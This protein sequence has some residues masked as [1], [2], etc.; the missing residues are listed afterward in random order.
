MQGPEPSGARARVLAE[1]GLLGLAFGLLVVAPWMRPGYLLL[2]DWVSGPE[3]G[4]TPGVFG[5]SGSSL[6]A[7]PFRLGTHALRVLV[8]PSATAWLLILAFF[9]LAAAGAA[10]A[11]GGGRWRAFPAAL[12][13]VCNPFVIDRIRAGHVAVLLGMAL[14]PWLFAAALQARRSHR[15]VAVR[16]ALWYALAISISPHLAWMGGLLLLAVA[17]L[18]RVTWRD[19]VRTVQVVLTGGLVYGYAIVLLATGTRTLNVTQADLDAYATDT[20]PGG[21][22]PTVLSLRG[23][24]RAFDESAVSGEG[25]LPGAVL[26]AVLLFVV[27]LGLRTRWGAETDRS[28]PLVALA[29][30]GLLLGAG[31]SGPLAG[32]YRLA[33]DVLPLFEAMREQQK[34]LALVVLAYAV[35]FGCGVEWLARQPRRA[36]SVEAVVVGALPLLMASGLVWG[37][38]GSVRTSDYPDGWTQAADAMGPGQGAVLFLPWHGY[39]PFDFTDGRT[40]ATPAAAFFARPTLVSD[41]VELPGLRTDSTSLRTAYVDR[42]VAHG[43]AQALGPLLAPLGVEYVAVAEGVGPPQETAWVAGQPGITRVMTSPT[44]TLYRVTPS[45]VGR[46]GSARVAD[47]DAAVT[48]YR[49]L[50]WGTKAVLAPDSGASLAGDTTDPRPSTASGGL[51]KTSATTWSVA[52]GEPGWVVIPEEWSAGWAADGIPAV[53]TLAG[54]A[55]VRVGSAATVVEYT[56]WRLLRPATIASLGV[57]LALIVGGL[58]EWRRARLAR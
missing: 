18:P 45:A 21:W 10:A 41:A 55:A 37:L 47:L 54:T 58:L 30:V 17:L 48:G 24:W 35:G 32:V 22:L 7:M 26:L 52:A 13:M 19:V 3:Q 31:V 20:G 15:S 23:F 27:G 29:V 28:A 33:F 36:A 43:G 51:T 49:D 11:A 50:G 44:M 2:L 25:L 6:D 40:V 8:G 53:P 56:P 34:W 38:G 12:L 5:L 46:V 16:P 57:L 39:Q 1:A 9:P 4:L 14:L 42:I